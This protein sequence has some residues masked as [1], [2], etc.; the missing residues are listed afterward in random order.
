MRP[1]LEAAFTVTVGRDPDAF[2]LEA[3]LLLDEGVLVLFGPSGSGKSLC[4]QTLV[5]AASPQRGFFRLGGETVFD[6]A[7]GLEV[8]THLRR[9]GYVPQHHA[10]FPFCSVRDNVLFGLPTEARRR[11]PEGV[12]TLMEEVGIA[13]LAE[14]MPERLSGG[15][16]QRVALARALA[17]SPRLLVLDEPFASIDGDGKR[18][19]LA[20]LRRVLESRGVPAVLVTH[21][22]V[23]ART[24]GTHVVRFARGKTLGTVSPQALG[25]PTRVTG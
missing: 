20:V 12:R 17:V 8:P 15:E 5:G 3:E 2:T 25:E 23:E 9:I 13:A 24:M 21:D 14:A 1:V 6:R 10:L 4:L 7:R 22:P 18:E 11:M 19:L 16:R